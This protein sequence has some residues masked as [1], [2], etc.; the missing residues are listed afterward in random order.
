MWVL[1]DLKG[2]RAVFGRRLSRKYPCSGNRCWPIGHRVV[3]EHD[4]GL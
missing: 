2:D 1:L 4:S 3:A